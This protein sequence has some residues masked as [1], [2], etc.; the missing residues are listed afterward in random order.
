MNAQV[1]VD[2]TQES[3]EG[4]GR[5]LRH[6]AEEWTSLMCCSG[7]HIV[8]ESRAE[9]ELTEIV[10][11]ELATI[12]EILGAFSE[13]ETLLLT[14]KATIERW[15]QSLIDGFFD[16]DNFNPTVI[17]EEDQE[18]FT[19]LLAQTVLMSRIGTEDELNRLSCSFE[20]YSSARTQLVK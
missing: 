18:A 6:L 14:C 5:T 17:Q 15:P 3:P 4:E 20:R 9:L 16:S 11:Q 19:S 1:T 7:C 13:R 10:G 8:E 2:S 12:Q